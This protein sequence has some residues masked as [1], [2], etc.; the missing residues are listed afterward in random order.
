MAAPSKTERFPTATHWGAYVAEVV[1]GRLTALTPFAKDGEPS[2][3]GQSQVDTLDDACRIRQPMVRAGWLENGVGSDRA[4]RGRQP[5]V[6]VAWERALDLVAGEIARVRD[7]HGNQAIFAGSYGWASAG[8]FHHAQSQL[9]RFFNQAGGYTASVNTYSFAAGEVILPH[10]CGGLFDLL[11]R[12]T[13]WSVIAE[14]TDL[15]VLF[16]GMPA[17]NTQ[18]NAGGIGS[19]TA[20]QGMRQCAE[21]GVQFAAI[22]PLKADALAELGA[23]WLQPRP[24]TDTAIMMGLAHTLVAEGLHDEAFLARYCVGFERFRPYLMGETDG[25][26]KDA[27]WAGRIAEIDAETIRALAR[28]MARGRTLVSISWSLQRADH[29]EQP[30]WM[31]VALA[32]L[33]GQIGLPGGG[34]GLGYGCVDSV[35]NGVRKLDWAAVPQGENPVKDFIPV[36]RISDLLLK[37]GETFTYDGRTLTYPDIHMVYWAGGNPFHH[38]QDLNRLIEAWRRPETIICHELWWNALA[39]HCDI[40]LPAT[41]PLERNDIAC[42]RTDRFMLAMH[43]AVAPTGQARNDHDIFADVAGRLGFRERFTE[44]RGEMEWLR[45][46]YDVTRQRASQAGVEFPSF[47]A[48]WEEGHVEV[49]L[50]EEAPVLFSEFRGAPDAHP[51]PTPSGKIEIF[52]ATIDA[53]AYPDCPGH[54]TWLEPAE[55]L[56]SERARRYPLHLMSNQP[57]TRLHAQLDNGAVSRA[58][59]VRGRE[60]LTMNPADAARRGIAAGDVV[61]V[62]NDRGA[63]LAGVVL[64]DGV[65]VGVVQLATGAWFDPVRPGEI[66]SLDRHGNPNMLTLD[67][68]TSSLAQGPIANSALVEVERFADEP[69]PITVFA[70]PALVDG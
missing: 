51:L 48:F 65:R 39:R 17:K 13:A 8:R 33:L 11:G 53:F 68:G 38:H 26:P 28:R 32:A 43:R 24:G 54:P 3:I 25:Q 6:P 58:S 1:D 9:H 63:C 34:F 27:E 40:V 60:P 20:A 22:S 64:S 56:G 41:T 44:G 57:K 16:G 47:E 35:G 49:A 31:L 21:A 62:Y 52:S 66:G 50:P 37:P 70:A 36:A 19:H 61:R 29:G 4:G 69:P 45:H 18:V 10:V 42:A 14:H 7:R 5:F 12:A 15:M 55:W 46:L 59:K 67:K 30:F 2:P 23:E